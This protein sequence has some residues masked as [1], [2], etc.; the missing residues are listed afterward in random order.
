[1]R[2]PERHT[3]ELIVVVLALIVV[4]TLL[5]TAVLIADADAVEPDRACPPGHT[6]A[7]D[8][9]GPYYVYTPNL[10]A[11]Y[12]AVW[13]NDQVTLLPPP[14]TYGQAGDRVIVCY[15][16]DI[17]TFAASLGTTTTTTVTP[18]I[19]ETQTCTVDGEPGIRHPD[20]SCWTETRYNQEFSDQALEQVPS[21]TDPGR[22]VGS[23]TTHA[24]TA[25]P[26]ER[27]RYF[28]GV[29]LPSFA[30]IIQHVWA[31]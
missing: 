8:T 18:P 17:Y 28:M 30:R 9:E 10:P 7:Q 14:G 27:T 13:V 19:A 12:S 15:T 25:P 23:Y 31:L 1:M 21:L 11:G 26:A 24:S 3:I 5:V 22:S 4:C 29:E 20:G 2:D 16:E 6:I